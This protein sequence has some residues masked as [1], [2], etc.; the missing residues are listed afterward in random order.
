MNDNK[1]LLVTTAVDPRNRLSTFPTYLK[2]NVKK[3]LN[4]N[5]KK[6]IFFEA[7]QDGDSSIL[8]LETPNHN[9]L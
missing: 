6:H 3:Q 5:I 7:D 1:L 2:N 8:P 4:V 9:P